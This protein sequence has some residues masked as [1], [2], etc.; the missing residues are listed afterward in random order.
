M[1]Q[2]TIF[3]CQIGIAILYQ[4]VKWLPL[5]K[6]KDKWFSAQYM[7][8]KEKEELEKFLEDFNARRVNKKEQ[9]NQLLIEDNKQNQNIK[10]R[11]CSHL[12]L[13]IEEDYF[14]LEE[15]ILSKINNDK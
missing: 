5:N 14:K 12:P 11:K 15:F 8:D 10:L 3:Y 2:T 1:Y 4:I 6:W 13:G 9:I 7:Q